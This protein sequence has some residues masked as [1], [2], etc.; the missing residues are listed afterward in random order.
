MV[1][2]T[3]NFLKKTLRKTNPFHSEYPQTGTLVDYEDLND[4]LHKAIFYQD[5]PCLLI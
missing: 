4:M 1:Q 2:P 5:M 3:L